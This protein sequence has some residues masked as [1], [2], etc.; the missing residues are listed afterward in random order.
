MMTGESEELMRDHTL[1]A[2]FATK[3]GQVEENEFAQVENIEGKSAAYCFGLLLMLG[4]GGY[5]FGYYMGIWNPLGQKHL[6]L[7]LGVE[8]DFIET[9]QGLINVCYAVGA[10]FG[11]LFGSFLAVHIGRIR[12][13]F[14]VD[15]L[16]LVTVIGY[17]FPY[18][19]LL[20]VTLV[21]SGFIAGV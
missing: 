4:S 21:S 8:D 10:M 5:Y 6:R 2:N 16:S 7:N 9:A 11:C 17:M 15:I 19:W 1:E 14:Y 18:L 13:I 20:Y 3:T 12:L